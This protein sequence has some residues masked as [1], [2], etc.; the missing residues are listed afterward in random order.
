MIWSYALPRDQILE[1]YYPYNLGG[2][3]VSGTAQIT[4][5]PLLRACSE[6]REVVT[7]RYRVED[8]VTLGRFTAASD[9]NTLVSDPLYDILYFTRAAIGC[10][11]GGNW[12]KVDSAG[13]GLRAFRV[14]AF[15]V[16][17]LRRWILSDGRLSTLN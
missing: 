17:D 8:S 11:I 4:L 3:R 5:I 15:R 13:L 14:V 7:S 6:S 2:T 10:S 9:D 1:I 16:N 12:Y